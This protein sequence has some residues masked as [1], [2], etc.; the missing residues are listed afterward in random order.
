MRSTSVTRRHASKLEFDRTAVLYVQMRKGANIFL[1]L[2]A[3]I[4]I[5]DPISSSSDSSILYQ[6]NNDISVYIYITMK[7]W[8]VIGETVDC[9]TIIVSKG[10]KR[11]RGTRVYCLAGEGNTPLEVAAHT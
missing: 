1:T 10:R 6:P 4:A 9:L 7:I 8:T 3:E 2:D 5:A 11:R